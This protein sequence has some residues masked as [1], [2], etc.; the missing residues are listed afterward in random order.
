[1]QKKEGN[2]P[3]ASSLT[4]KVDPAHKLGGNKQVGFLCFPHPLR[5]LKSEE[6]QAPRLKLFVISSRHHMFSPDAASLS[7][8]VLDNFHVSPVFWSE[9]NNTNKQDGPPFVASYFRFT[10]QAHTLSLFH[11]SEVLPGTPSRRWLD[12]PECAPLCPAVYLLRSGI[13]QFFLFRFHTERERGR[14]G[15]GGRRETAREGQWQ[16]DAA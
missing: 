8:I 4:H 7:P 13:R 16:R 5:T 2:L 15:R 9:T 11:F 14:G 12:S 10:I 1:M 3:L 6:I